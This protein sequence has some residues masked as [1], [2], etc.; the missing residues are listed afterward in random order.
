MRMIDERPAEV[1]DRVQA[2]HWEGDLIMG[3]GNRSAIGTLV[4]RRTRFLVLVQLPEGVST[5][6]AVRGI[7]RRADQ[8]AHRVASDLD[9]GSGQGARR[10]P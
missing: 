4:E 3:M 1:E 7:E 5:A 10:T 9:L 2:G 8:A 6:Q